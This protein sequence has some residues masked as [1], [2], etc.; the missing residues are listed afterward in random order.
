MAAL[1]PDPGRQQAHKK[2]RK[3]LANLPADI[4]PFKQFLEEYSG[5]PTEEVE[6]VILD[7]VSV[8]RDCIL[9]FFFL[10]Y[11]CNGVLDMKIGG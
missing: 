8:S 7:I 1:G 10:I 6:A 9:F 2:E 3:F 11:G 5:I 4:G